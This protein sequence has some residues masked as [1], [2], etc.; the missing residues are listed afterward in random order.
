MR[1]SCEL[2]GELRRRRY[3]VSLMK[4]NETQMKELSWRVLYRGEWNLYC[5]PST[6][7]RKKGKKKK[8]M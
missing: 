7:M 3:E 6:K 8:D 5:M 2:L 1:Q 4:R